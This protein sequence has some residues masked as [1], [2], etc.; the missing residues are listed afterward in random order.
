M[1]VPVLS[2]AVPVSGV[3]ALPTTTVASLRP[4]ALRAGATLSA[5]PPSSPGIGSTPRTT[6]TLFDCSSETHSVLPG[7]RVI[8]RGPELAG[9]VIGVEYTPV[10]VSRPRFCPENWA[11]Q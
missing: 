5:G 8:R 6:P 10:E 9:N 4:T 3:A 11:T 2:A 1:T 7:P